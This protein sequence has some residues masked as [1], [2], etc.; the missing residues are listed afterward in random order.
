MQTEKLRQAQEDDHAIRTTLSQYNGAP[1][2]AIGDLYKQGRYSAANLLGKQVYDHRKAQADAYQQQLDNYNKRLKVSGNIMSGV[3]DDPSYQNARPA[4]LAMLQPVFGQGVNDILPTS[5]DKDHIDK[6]LKMGM[7][8]QER[9][10]VEQNAV[11][12]AKDAIRLQNQT[13]ND[14]ETYKKNQLEARKYWQGALSTGLGN[15]RNQSEWDFWQEQAVTN[16]APKDLVAGYGRQ[17]SAENAAHAKSLGMTS[18]QDEA[19]ARADAAA[20]RSDRRLTLAEEAA[21]RAQANFDAG[22][23]GGG[24]GTK[25]TAGALSNVAQETAKEYAKLETEIRDTYMIKAGK[26]QGEYAEIP[27][28]MQQEYGRRRMQ[29][30]NTDRKARLLPTY[31]ESLA[32][33]QTSGDTAGAAKLQAEMNNLLGGVTTGKKP[34]GDTTAGAPAAA[35]AAPRKLGARQDD[36]TRAEQLLK[37]L[38]T[39]DPSTKPKIQAELREILQRIQPTPTAR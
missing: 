35:P 29:I 3:T 24:R 17:W 33:A 11:T 38:K 14:N 2:D 30:A 13:A 26:Q 8:A 16:G 18:A 21:Q 28:A 20:A 10:Q 39:A 23:A 27:P 22:G 4:V 5:Y 12:N 25:L 15:A 9:N 37:D 31:E 6:L 32:Q 19:A 7:D 36:A 34:T 1:D